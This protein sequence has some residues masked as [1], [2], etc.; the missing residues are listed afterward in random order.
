MSITEKI[1]N[2]K[3]I[4][5]ITSYIDAANELSWG[6]ALI[7]KDM[8]PNVPREERRKV[9]C[10]MI[11]GLSENTFNRPLMIKRIFKMKMIDFSEAMSNKYKTVDEQVEGVLS[12]LPRFKQHRELLKQEII[13]YRNKFGLKI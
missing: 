8:K 1:K 13:K 3:F 5:P 9:L 12:W 2:S 11:D 4:Y 10:G 7:D 6:S